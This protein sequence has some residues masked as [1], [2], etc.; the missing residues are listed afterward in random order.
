MGTESLSPRLLV[1]TLLIALAWAPRLDAQSEIPKT[2]SPVTD[3][4]DYERREVM[5]PMRDGVKLHTVIVIPKGAEAAP[6]ILTRT[7]YGAEKV[8]TQASSP[9]IVM[10]LPPADETL[11]R[12]GYIR[13]YQDI[14]GRYKSE[15]D[16]VMTLPP[17]GPLNRWKVDQSTDTYD[18]IDWLVKNV[19]ESNGRVGLTGVSYPG[20]LTLM[21]ILE[22]HP[23][24]KGAVPMYPMVDGWMGDDFY[25]NGALRQT[26]FEWIYNLGADKSSKYSP[27]FGYRDMYEAYLSAG[28]ADAVARRYK[29]DRLATWRKIVDNPSYNAFWRGQA[30]QHL[31]ADAPLKLPVLVVHGLFDQED[32]FGGIAAYRALEANDRGNDMVYL[33]VGPW[34]HGQ[35]EREGSSLGA[36]QWSSDTSLWFRQQV[37]L[38]FWDRHLKA[39]QSTKSIA[40]VTAFDTGTKEWSG[41]QSWP[42]NGKVATTRL[43]LRSGGKLSF[44]PPAADGPHY[45]EFVSDPAK[46]VPYRVR[47]VLAMYNSESSWNRWLVDDQRPFSDR[48]DVLTFVSSP[49]S[50]PLTISGEVFATL[51]AAT[52]GTDA[53]WVVKLI[54]VFPPEVRS[55]P[56]LGGYQLMV[57][58]DIM[59][60]RYRQNAE[61]AAPIEPGTVA[62]YRVRMPEANHTFLPGHRI[63]VHVQSSWFPLYDRNPQTFVE[64]V[65]KAGPDD[66]RAATHRI[67]FAPGQ[68]SFIE[69][70]L[71]S[72]VR[73]Q[74]RMTGSR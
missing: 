34:N 35:S 11:V 72:G 8:T 70:P 36:L 18:T 5:I 71:V 68:A 22:P 20:W 19:K 27:P 32:N 53:D 57:S 61:T 2:F 40:P 42:A 59:R 12:A 15:G 49:L 23:A 9:H 21:G 37:L 58:G 50:A 46:P 64:N 6:I 51:F 17:R 55:N 65:A 73:T 25:H 29:A 63:M 47:P 67:W 28:S 4:F 1:L 24:L 3:E 69:L 52:T 48:T 66:Y 39:E 60:G 31:L 56:A 54:D 14:R 33:A 74:A 45:A 38:P 7:P 26:M 13:A 62:P 30:V 43:H 10:I 16:Y 44:D 41:Y